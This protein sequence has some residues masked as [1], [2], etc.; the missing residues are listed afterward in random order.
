LA[1]NE[2]VVS[3]SLLSAGGIFWKME[4]DPY[5]PADTFLKQPHAERRYRLM[6]CS[7]R[8][9]LEYYSF[10]AEVQKWQILL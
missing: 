7:L 2:K 9:C 8:Q 4:H 10:F 6:L 3:I 1:D 5:G